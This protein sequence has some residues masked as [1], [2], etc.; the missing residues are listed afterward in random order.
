VTINKDLSTNTIKL[1][2]FNIAPAVTVYP[3]PTEKLTVDLVAH[4]QNVEEFISII[5]KSS[6]AGL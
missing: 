5:Q 6:V 3:K 1:I 4:K 2:D